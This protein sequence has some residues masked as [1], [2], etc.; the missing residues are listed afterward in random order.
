MS[1][2]GRRCLLLAVACLCLPALAWAD[3]PQPTAETE[4][5]LADFRG[6]VEPLVQKFCIE[7]HTGEEPTGGLVFDDYLQ[8]VAV[9]ED[10]QVW[11]QIARK[12]HDHEMP[13]DDSP[14]PSGDERA[15]ITSWI[16]GQLARFGC[17]EER[18]PGRV[19]IRRLNRNEYDNTI[20]D[21]FGVDFHPADDFPSD[22]VGYGFDNIGD[23]LSLPTI[24]LEKY[25]AAAEK[26][27]ARA[28]GTEQVNLV[29]SDI[30]GGQIVDG[31]ARF[32]TSSETAVHTKV[33]MFG[34]GDY[35]FRVRAWGEQAGD[36]PVRMGIYLDKK[37]VRQFEVRATESDPQVYEGWLHSRGGRHTYTIT[38][39]NDYYEPDQPV[40][41]DRNLYVSEIE[42]MGP[43][44]STARRIIPREHTPEDKLQLAR[45]I[46]TGV[47]FRAYRR[48]PAPAE[49][50]L[51]ARAGEDGRP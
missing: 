21:L 43:Y 4:Q 22:D 41:N 34:T 10:R 26:V 35:I 19:T 49:V 33:R 6:Q 27:A 7:C 3:E 5:A 14:Q 11:E 42:L 29:T 15:K 25:L 16:D 23:V 18:D 24:L 46:I 48:P 13:P 31:G 39:E 32:V 1:W 40:P 51:R 36:E 28:L 37:L 12:L 2:S 38:F 47:M 50:D 45:E 20:R 44:P 30:N 9:G 8:R 17:G